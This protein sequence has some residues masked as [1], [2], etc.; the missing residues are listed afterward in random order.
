MIKKISK[1]NIFFILALFLSICIYSLLISTNKGSIKV[2]DVKSSNNISNLEQGVTRFS[3]VEY[4][5]SSNKGRDYITRGEE[6]YILNNQ[7][8]LIHLNYVHSF[9]Q[10]KDGSTLNIRSDKAQ[11]L[12][13]NKNI[14]YYKSVVITNN[15]KIINASNADFFAS[16]NLIKLQDVVYKD[17]QNLLKSDS[18]I[19]DILTNNLEMRMEDNKNQ[20]YGYR[21][22]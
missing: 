16:K 8:D 18:A 6:A 12:K 22:Q 4:K 2:N 14:K 17:R 3:N 19:L 15:E 7:P 1:S 9:T 5:T 10:L 21:K 20:V 13:N 11:Y